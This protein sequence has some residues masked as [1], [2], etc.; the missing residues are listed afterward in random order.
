[1]V[2]KIPEGRHPLLKPSHEFRDL[3]PHLDLILCFLDPAHD[4]SK[5][6]FHGIVFALCIRDG[7]EK[8]RVIHFSVN[9]ARNGDVI[10]TALERDTRTQLMLVVA[11]DHATFRAYFTDT[12]AIVKC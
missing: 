6:S 4:F 9:I 8:A 5:F 3:Y 12:S 2:R 1:M 10:S 11:Q 7:F